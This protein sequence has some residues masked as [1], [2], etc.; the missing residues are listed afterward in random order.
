MLSTIWTYRNFIKASVVRELKSKY[1]KS[2]FGMLWALLNPLYMIIAYT[3]I[4][5]NT[6]LP[7]LNKFS[8]T[9]YVASGVLT[10]NFFTDILLRAQNIYIGNANIIKKLNFPHLCLPLVV[11][12]NAW[13][14]FAIAFGIFTL[15]LILTGNFPGWNYLA[16]IPILLVQTVLGIGLGTTLGIF[17]VFFRDVEQS[18]TVVFQIWFWMTPIV[19]L[20]EKL[21]P[22]I[23][24]ILIFNP[25]TA[26]VDAYHKILVDQ[27]Y[28]FS[29][30]I[31]YPITC[32]I[33]ICTL[34]FWLY[35]KHATE[36][37]DEL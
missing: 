5:S 1:G 18:L 16:L 4:F 27:Q 21:P 10:W 35:Q 24:K 19:Y 23:Q 13:I 20:K 9:V 32:A 31:F 12:I 36:I 7:N 30:S 8:Y 11:V 26:I 28:P 15:F 34:S 25:I 14:N 29:P 22:T 2:L 17:N 3:I 37:L 33:L 6:L